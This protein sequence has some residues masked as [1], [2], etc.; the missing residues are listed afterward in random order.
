MKEKRVDVRLFG[1]A[2]VASEMPHQQAAVAAAHHGEFFGAGIF[3]LD[4]MLRAR[5]EIRQRHF[6]CA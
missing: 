3:A 6:V 5:D 1:K 2:D 4:K